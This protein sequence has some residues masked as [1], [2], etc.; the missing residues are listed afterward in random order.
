VVRRAILS[1]L[2]LTR[3]RETIMFSLRDHYL[4]EELDRLKK[5]LRQNQGPL[6]QQV[7]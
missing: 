6:L 3:D 5:L 4:T 7:L 2:E 1:M